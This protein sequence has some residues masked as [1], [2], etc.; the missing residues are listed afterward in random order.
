M[1]LSLCGVKEK[2]ILASFAEAAPN[3]CFSFGFFPPPVCSHSLWW[4]LHQDISHHL[5]ST[6]QLLAVSQAFAASLIGQSVQSP[7][8]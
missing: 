1:C 5:L 3:I 8:E 7:S 2:N 4:K 6:L